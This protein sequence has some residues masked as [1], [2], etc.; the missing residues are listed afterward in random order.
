MLRKTNANAKALFRTNLAP[1]RVYGDVVQGVSEEVANEMRVITTKVV[2]SAGVKS[3]K[4]AEITIGIG[5]RH[6]PANSR[7]TEQA[8]AW[9]ETWNE[10]S[11]Q[12]KKDYTEVWQK[13]LPRLVGRMKEGELDKE[14]SN[15][16][17]SAIVA[18]LFK[19]GWQP[20]APNR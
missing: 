13:K 8:K 9:I 14:Q 18:R 1:C 11:A 19:Q 4:T 15:R 3:C 16:P 10:A 7:P 20:A 12:E 2:V 17:I 5:A 6:D